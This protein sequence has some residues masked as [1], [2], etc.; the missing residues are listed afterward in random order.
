MKLEIGS[1]NLASWLATS[2]ELKNLVFQALDLRPYDRQLAQ[3]EQAETSE[4]ACVFLGCPLGPLLAAQVL[5][6]H[7]IVFPE[8]PG[9]VF[10]PY[11]EQLYSPTELYAG[12][13]ANDP[14]SYGQTPDRIIYETFMELDAEGWPLKPP[15]HKKVGMEE[16]MA[17]R[18]HDHFISTELESFLAHFDPRKNPVKRGVV[19]IM[20]GHDVDRD[21][22]SFAMVAHLARRLA[23]MGFLIASGGGPGLMEAANL[24]AYFAA[25]SDPLRLES[26]IGRLKAAPSY[27]D[28]DWLAVGWRVLQEHPTPSTEASTSLGI[29]TWFYGHEPPNV[30]ATHIAK[31]FENSLREEGLLAIATHGILFANGNA[32]TVQEI[33]QDA[34]Q[35][36]YSSYGHQSPMVLLGSNFWD[37]VPDSSGNF[38]S[39]SKPAWQLLRHLAR[40]GGFEHLIT[41]TDDPDVALRAFDSFRVPGQS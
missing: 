32:G 39:K 38:R 9:L 3:L 19:A 28:K 7:A 23:S 34:C 22:P 5:E 2:T 37:L 17:R 33:F 36:Y 11:R 15:R 14:S 25:F 26:A 20:G 1:D 10:K 40:V 18:L 41:L 31:Y 16:L 8:L 24:G 4:D 35:N 21:D 6:H 27:K 29:P 13:E 12:F 30:F